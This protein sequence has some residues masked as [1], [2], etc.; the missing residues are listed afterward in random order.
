[1]SERVV[2]IG[3]AKYSGQKVQEG[4][5]GAREAA[6]AL[7]GI[8]KVV[9]HFIHEDYP[10]LKE[11][12]FEV[13]TYVRKGS[14]EIVI[15]EAV[16][17][18]ALAGGSIV[19][20]TYLATASTQVAKHVFKDVGSKDILKRALN[21]A[22]W[23]M[24]I[25]KHVGGLTKQKF[26]H[27]K[28]TQNGQ[29]IGIPDFQSRYLYVPKSAVQSFNSCPQ[30]LFSEL[31]SLVENEKLL[32]IGTGY[33]EEDSTTVSAIERDIFVSEKEDEE[34][35]FPDLKHGQNIDLEG[36]ITRGN[37][38]ANTLGLEYQGHGLT[39]KPKQGSIAS[40]KDR[41]ISTEP[42]HFYPR[43][44]ITGSID[45]TDDAGGTEKTKPIILF[46]D[47]IPINNNVNQEL[48]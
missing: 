4:V 21:S 39:G 8:D 15:P 11:E 28:F 22:Q 29:I 18:W 19:L 14:W 38:K 5:M 1:M 35:L 24:K 10:D 45:R 20:T 17:T 41:L 3:Y 12:D 26:E 16:G 34:M 7:S 9:R 25:A 30:S 46:S 43:A 2:A 31:T 42:D 36:L 23:V 44:T 48:F 27:V 32:T 40:Y 6:R 33:T 37:E 47:I 13:P